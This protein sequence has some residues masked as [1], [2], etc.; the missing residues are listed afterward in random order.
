MEPAMYLLKPSGGDVGVKLGGA[1]TGVPQH[2]LNHPEVCA[3][4]EEVRG[5]T[6]A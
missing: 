5:K 3:V 2:F 4:F 6:V 1:D